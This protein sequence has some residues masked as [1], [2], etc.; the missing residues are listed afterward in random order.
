MS[1]NVQGVEV[2]LKK[3]LMKFLVGFLWAWL[4]FILFMILYKG[5]SIDGFVKAAFLSLMAIVM[6]FFAA[7]K[8]FWFFLFLVGFPFSLLV[9]VK[10]IK[11]ISV[12]VLVA[13]NVIVWLLVGVK[14]LVFV[15][16][17]A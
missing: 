8:S 10:F 12:E 4:L 2:Q 7:T 16:G 17:G 13:I 14:A 1:I 3:E 15:T 11:S 9:Q 5:L 6:P